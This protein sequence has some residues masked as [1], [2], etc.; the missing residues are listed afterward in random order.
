MRAEFCGVCGARDDGL[1]GKD[2]DLR[3]FTIEELHHSLEG[4]LSN[5]ET[6]CVKEWRHMARKGKFWGESPDA[7]DQRRGTRVTSPK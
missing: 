4:V 5:R 6:I 7:H 3:V 2:S 1:E